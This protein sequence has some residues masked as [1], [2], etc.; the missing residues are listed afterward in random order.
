MVL[1]WPDLSVACQRRAR[2]VNL[3]IIDLGTKHTQ[4]FMQVTMT[5]PSPSVTQ[6]PQMVLLL[7]Y[8]RSMNFT[9][10]ECK[11]VGEV[12]ND[13][14]MTHISWSN[15]KITSWENLIFRNIF[16]FEWKSNMWLW[17]RWTYNAALMHDGATAPLW[18]HASYWITYWWLPRPGM[19]EQYNNFFTS[20]SCV[21]CHAWLPLRLLGILCTLHH[22]LP[23]EKLK[24][25]STN[26]VVSSA[27]LPE[28]YH[29]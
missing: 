22:E 29:A 24:T 23:P 1:D 10:P 4:A 14:A 25:I 2:L 27:L 12:A 20:T 16:L 5:S 15:K 13:P 7:T 3:P 6:W 28:A 19:A 8:Y 26:N 17:C 21:M 18:Q 11:C 9:H